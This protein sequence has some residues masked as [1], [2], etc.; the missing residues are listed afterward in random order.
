MARDKRNDYLKLIKSGIDPIDNKREEE[1]QKKA[2]QEKE[3]ITIIY[4]VEQ[5]FNFRKDELSQST[6]TKDISRIKFSFINKLV[7][8]QPILIK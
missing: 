1:S 2:Q 7:T 8:T 4:L 5:Y 3:K 6:I